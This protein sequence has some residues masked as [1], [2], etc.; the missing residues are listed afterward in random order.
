MRRFILAMTAA[1][2]V[3]GCAAEPP[4]E[5]VAQAFYELCEIAR[6]DGHGA[7]QNELFGMLSAASQEELTACSE[8]LSEALQLDPPMEAADCLVFDSYSGKSRDFAARRVA[9]GA[10]RVRLEITSGETN[11]IL[12]MVHEDG[13]R[14][15]LAA[16]LALNT[17]PIALTP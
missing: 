9:D 7:I 10:A 11:R 8:R 2:V 15:D 4:P 16:T 14:I 6:Q 17:D 13:W 5:A 12:E 3:A 1:M